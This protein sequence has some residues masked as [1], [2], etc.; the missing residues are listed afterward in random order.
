M[1]T[2]KR[3]AGLCVILMLLWAL[4]SHPARGEEVYRM[5]KATD[6]NRSLYYIFPLAP[7]TPR[8]AA[9]DSTANASALPRPNSIKIEPGMKLIFRA[10]PLRTR[11][12]NTQTP[13]LMVFEW[14]APE[15]LVPRATNRF[16]RED[17]FFLQYMLAAGVPVNCD[18]S[19]TPTDQ[20]HCD[21]IEQFEELK[22]IVQTDG[23][24]LPFWERLSQRVLVPSL[25][26]LTLVAQRNSPFTAPSR[27]STELRELLAAPAL[28]DFEAKEERSQYLRLS[29]P[30]RYKTL[31]VNVYDWSS[32]FFNDSVR[33]RQDIDKSQPWYESGGPRLPSGARG[34][35][36]VMIPARVT[37]KADGQLSLSNYF[38]VY[39]SLADMEERLGVSIRGVRRR[40][41][42]VGNFTLVNKQLDPQRLISPRD[43]YFTLWFD[44]SEKGYGAKAILSAEEQSKADVLLA[45]GDIVI[46]GRKRLGAT[47]R[48]QVR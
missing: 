28:E 41:D 26:S 34:Y 16:T 18:S 47:D 44:K 29:F 21:P 2:F 7:L 45:P 30:G 48:P 32:A 27:S 15:T 20:S 31:E 3:H 46:V 6:L 5:A 14:I 19:T 13:G 43:G 8:A 24:T 11:G 9:G 36:E 17:Y 4:V 25:R 39:F 1:T 23:S 37:D 38:P 22:R 12:T 42:F 10:V 40:E 35:I 33:E